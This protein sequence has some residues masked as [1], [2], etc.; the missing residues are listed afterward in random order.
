MNSLFP[1]LVE[2]IMSNERS[3]PRNVPIFYLDFIPNIEKVFAAVGKTDQSNFDSEKSHAEIQAA[4]LPHHTDI[5]SKIDEFWLEISKRSKPDVIVLVSPAHLDQGNANVQTTNGIWKTPF[6]DVQTDARTI[7]DLGISLEPKS[8][9]NEQGI[10]T[11]MP[12]IAYYF[13][14]VPVVPVIAPSRSGMTDADAFVRKLF[15][16]DKKILLI[17]SIDF[18]HYLSAEISDANDLETQEAIA[19]RDFDRIDKMNSDYLD[20]SFALDTFLF[21]KGYSGC[22]AQPR[23]HEYNSRLMSGIGPKDGTSYFVYYCSK[24]PLARISAVGDIMLARG[25]GERL[26]YDHINQNITSDLKKVDVL[27]KSV[28]GDSDLLFGNLESVLSDKG[29]PVQ[30][31]YVFEAEPRLVDLLSEWRFSHLSVANNHNSD[32]G[33]EAWE[34]S[35]DVLRTKGIVPVGGYSNE[36]KIETVTAGGQEFAFLGFENLVKP[37]NKQDVLSAITSAAKSHGVVVVSMHWGEEYQS[38]P[39]PETVLLAHEM[40]DAGADIIFGHHPHVLQPV[41]RYKKGLIFYSLGNFIFDQFGEAQNTSMI[42]TVDVFENGEL[43]YSTT[44]VLIDEGFPTLK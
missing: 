30:K 9:V 34:Q 37:F 16:L 18:S 20:S 10:A 38:T 11:H 12:F 2:G 7:K 40:I 26:S 33:R 35:V 4:I 24:R 31:E 41:E 25:I 3:L 23:W 17:A 13:P 14:D 21:W 8:F 15:S 29:K 1:E 27:M 6:G 28:T 43:D 19:E 32:Y 44:P 39:T 36:A 5:G 22:L 42:A